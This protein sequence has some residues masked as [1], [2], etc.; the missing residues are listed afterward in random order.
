MYPHKS[1][2]FTYSL[3]L[4]TETDEATRDEKFNSDIN[5]KCEEIS[6]DDEKTVDAGCFPAN[7][8]SQVTKSTSLH[9]C[10]MCAF[11]TN[12]SQSLQGHLWLKH[13][14]DPQEVEIQE[15]IVEHQPSYVTEQEENLVVRVKDSSGK[16][17]LKCSLC[18]FETE[19]KHRLGVHL[20]KK[21][22]LLSMWYKCEFCLYRTNK[23]CELKRHERMHELRCALCSHEVASRYALKLHMLSHSSSAQ[24][25]KCKHCHYETKNVN[26]MRRHT[27]MS[28]DSSL[29]LYKCELCSYKTKDKW[30][31]EKHLLLVH[32][33]NAPKYKCD[34]C[35]WETK[36]RD[37]LK[38]HFKAKHDVNS[39]YE[40]HSCSFQTKS[41]RG[42]INH[43]RKTHNPNSS[44][45]KEPP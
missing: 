17:L 16:S 32:D 24:L 30:H 21:H 42:F 27:L 7:E 39:L 8:S 38:L 15:A 19:H 43:W 3:F 45:V 5:V 12:Q 13:E 2:V 41:R 14:I 35:S 36:Y 22:N 6:V 10:H 25:Y 26:L 11:E 1:Q 23:H 33:P 31:L 29:P 9:K 18:P 28:H 4:I 34:V 44:K 40:C 37:C 20:H